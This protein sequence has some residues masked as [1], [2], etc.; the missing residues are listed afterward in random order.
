MKQKEY[1]HIGCGATTPKEWL[2]FDGSY[3]LKLQRLPIT[4]YLIK[5][6][7][8][9]VFESHVQYADIRKPLP[10]PVNSVRAIYNSHM[11]VQMTPHEIDLALKNMYDVLKPSGILRVVVPDLK[12]LVEGYNWRAE[13]QPKEAAVFFNRASIMAMEHRPKGIKQRLEAAFGFSRNAWLIDEPFLIDKLQKA[14]FK[15][16]RLASYNDSNELMFK[17]VEREDRFSGAICIE[18]IK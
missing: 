8:N 6:I 17:L 13:H 14:G 11:L 10:L 2:N 4:G 18:A 16:M 3:T 5:K 12:A 9:V 1:V 7:S 15:N